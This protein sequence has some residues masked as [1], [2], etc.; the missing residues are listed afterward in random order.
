MTMAFNLQSPFHSPRI[1]FTGSIHGGL[2]QGKAITITG[3]VLPKADRFNVNLECGSRA[4]SDIAFHFNPRYD[5]YPGYVVANTL[6]HASWGSEER[7]QNSPF[8][9]GSN[10]SLMITVQLDSYQ[11]TVNG[12]HFLS[13]RHRIPFNMVDTISVAG[14][15]EVFTIAFQNPVLP[16][17]PSF[18]AQPGFPPQPSYFPQPG[19]PSVP[20]FPPQPG[21]PAASPVLPYKTII[22]GGQYPGRTITI[23]GVISPNATRFSV[24]LRFQSGIALHYNPRFNENTVVRNSNLR[25]KWGSEERYGAMP[26]HRGQPFTLSICCEANTY[27]IAVNGNHTHSYKHRHTALQQID[28]L[29]IDGDISLTSVLV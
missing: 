22:S 5:R 9:A 24:N 18:P 12:F 28:I 7:T 11:V 10:F 29:E 14:A 15:V 25:E 4:N 26:F 8:A 6:Q 27:R 20:G 3:R 13:Y 21:F 16:P 19:F 2:Q 23:Q 1:P 17:Q